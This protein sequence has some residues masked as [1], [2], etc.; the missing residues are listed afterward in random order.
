MEEEVVE[1][2]YAEHSENSSA[3]KHIVAYI[4]DKLDSIIGLSEKYSKAC[5]QIGKLEAELKGV[6]EKCFMIQEA[7]EK[8]IANLLKELNKKDLE[9]DKKNEEIEELKRRLDM[10]HDE[11]MNK[12]NTPWIKKLTG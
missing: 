5:Y 7:S 8:D 2:V 11:V 6:E 10:V 12:R 1:S 3:N 9:L 4:D